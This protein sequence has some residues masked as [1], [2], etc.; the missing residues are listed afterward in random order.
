M[1]INGYGLTLVGDTIGA[2]TGVE[3]VTVGGVELAF[4]EVATVESHVEGTATFTSG[5]ATVSGSGSGWTADMAG[6]R[7][8]RNNDST[9]Y[10]IAS[11]AGATSLTLTANF[12]AST[13]SGAYTILPSRLVESLPMGV[14]ESPIEVTLVYVKALYDTLL[15]ALAARTEDE[16]TLTDSGG[17]T[18]VG[19]GRIRSVGNVTFGSDGH[20][21]F[22]V[23]IQPTTC[24]AFTAAA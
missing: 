2:F 9:W 16:W 21:A 12:A 4:D 8:R 15:T 7:I 24:W 1:G 18:H 14:R 17:S 11:V 20:A 10:T 23:S 6:R 13:G 22:T 3:S 19:D 5:S